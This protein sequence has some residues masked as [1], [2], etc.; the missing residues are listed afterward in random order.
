MRR[1][2][3]LSQKMGIEVREG[4]K[5]LHEIKEERSGCGLAPFVPYLSIRTKIWK[6]VKPGCPSS[7]QWSI[8]GVVSS[9]I[10]TGCSAIAPESSGFYCS[11]PCV[12]FKGRPLVGFPHVKS[13]VIPAIATTVIIPNDFK[14]TLCIE[15]DDTVLRA[16]IKCRI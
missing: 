4:E 6:D 15:Y 11:S 5:F 9:R 1:A 8:P 16:P 10:G 7:V 14:Q 13:R 12:P 2:E 3:T